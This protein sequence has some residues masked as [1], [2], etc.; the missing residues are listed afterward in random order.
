MLDPFT[1]LKN[2]QENITMKKIIASALGLMMV[3]GVAASTA[4]AFESEFGGYWR[5]RMVAA[6]NMT[7]GDNYFLTDNRTRLY[8]TAKFND[9]FKFVNKFEFNTTWGD[10]G[11]AGGGVGADGRGIFRIK[12]SYIDA[13]FGTTNLK[14]GIQGTGIARGFI[15]AD[16]FSG[17]MVTMDL[18]SVA[19]TPFYI[20][21][22]SEDGGDADYDRGYFGAL[23]SVK[24]SDAI[25]LNPYVMYDGAGSGTSV[26]DDGVS[27][28]VGD[29]E[30]L[31]IGTDF[32]MKMDAVSLWGTAIY[33]NSSILNVD[34]DDFL[35]AVGVNAGIAHGQAFYASEDFVSAPGSSYYWSEILGLGVFDQAA[36]GG[37]DD[38]ITN[39]WAVNGGVTLK[40]MDKLT[41]DADV[42]Y[43][44]LTEDDA[45]GEDELGLEFDGKLT[46]ALMDNLNAEFIL[47]YLVAGDA[48]GDDDVFEGGVRVSLKF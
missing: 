17:A 25:S 4:S 20:A 5:T 37:P 34:S 27:T 23:A 45:T 15:F 1:G 47:A 16:D 6:D 7:Q 11:L 33:N 42:W 21:V 44:M 29:I 40:P 41:I 35:G 9:D 18:G 36:P 48:V 8:Y 43:A 28:N 3:G 13:N 39:V 30:N 14:L 19:V 32:D 24:I 31:Y 46:Y 26:D 38:N 2:T 22:L 10:S 12:N